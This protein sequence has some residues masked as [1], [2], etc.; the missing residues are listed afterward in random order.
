MVQMSLFE[1]GAASGAG[2][3]EFEGMLRRGGGGPGRVDELLGKVFGEEGGRAPGAAAGTGLLR[4]AR[5]DEPRGRSAESVAVAR[6]GLEALPGPVASARCGDPLPSLE[7]AERHERSGAART[8]RER[9]LEVVRAFP[10][11]ASSEIAVIAGLER[12]EAARRL[13]E[14]AAR[15]WI[16]QEGTRTVAVEGGGVRSLGVAWWPVEGEKAFERGDAE[17]AKGAKEEGSRA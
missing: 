14:V 13:P 5:N 12:H 8:N 9:V 11:L 7:A 3:V 10:G 1:G 15:G 2:P 6:L 4:F 17:G 16:K